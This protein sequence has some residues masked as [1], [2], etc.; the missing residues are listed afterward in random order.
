[1]KKKILAIVCLAL[2]GGL[3]IF[4]ISACDKDTNCYVQITVVDEVTHA[5]IPGVFVKIDIEDSYVNA[6][7][8][9]NEAGRF[10][11]VFSAPAIFNVAAIYETGYDSVYTRQN[12]FCYRKGNNTIRLKEG[13]TVYSTVNLES[14]I[15]R[16]YRNN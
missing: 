11:T 3:S 16:E 7:G 9:T 6:Q 12:F 13:D 8:L 1:M 14:E 15:H 5:P 2:I 10:D 4:S